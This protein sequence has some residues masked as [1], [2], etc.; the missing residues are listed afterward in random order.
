MQ[1]GMGGEIMDFNTSF[2]MYIP[3]G[4]VHGPLLWPKV[5]KPHIEMAIMLNCPTVQ[6]GWGDTEQVKKTSAAK[7]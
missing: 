3:K 1:F 6:D 2:G 5:R 4:M 7:K